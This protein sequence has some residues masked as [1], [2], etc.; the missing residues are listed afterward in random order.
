MQL[1]YSSVTTWQVTA[2]DPVLNLT[3]GSG[4]TRLRVTV[5]GRSAA[6]KS[7]PPADRTGIP[8]TCSGDTWEVT[9]PGPGDLARYERVS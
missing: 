5:D 2:T 8:Y 7:V 4:D 3:G 6:S 9:G 1:T